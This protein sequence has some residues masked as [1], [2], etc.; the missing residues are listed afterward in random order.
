MSYLKEIKVKDFSVKMVEEICASLNK[1]HTVE[2]KREK[3]GKI[4]IVDIARNV[5]SRNSTE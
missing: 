4:V 1:G 5:I 2:I 3:E